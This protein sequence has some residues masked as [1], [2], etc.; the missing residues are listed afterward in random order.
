MSNTSVLMGFI[1]GLVIAA[2]G[3]PPN[4]SAQ[5]TTDGFVSSPAGKRAFLNGDYAEAERYFREVLR[6]AEA[7]NA[8]PGQ[9]ATSI[10]NL[11][12]VLES[13]GRFKEAEELFDRALREASAPVDPRVRTILLLNLSVLYTHTDRLI[14]AESVLDEVV[15]LCRKHFGPDSRELSIALK[16]QGIV[17]AMTRRVSKAETRL[18]E[19]LAI[20][21]KE[22]AVPP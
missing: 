5:T 7:E 1:L 19:A 4:A 17:Y 22:P 3:F 14:R 2:G 15:V 13:L 10:G 12:Q 16:R 20:A 18:K 21:E 6:N 11:A 9:M 8:S